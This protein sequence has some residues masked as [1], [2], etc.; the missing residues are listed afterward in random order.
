MKDYDVKNR[1]TSAGVLEGNVLK[2]AWLEIKST[3][4]DK[5]LETGKKIWTVL[6]KAVKLDDRIRKAE[7]LCWLNDRR[8]SS[9]ENV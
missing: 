7:C 3:K 6:D 1:P 2:R 4:G 5:S 9:V 8:Q